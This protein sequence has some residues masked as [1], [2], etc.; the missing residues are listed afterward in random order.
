MI[1]SIEGPK[2]P[3]VGTNT[4]VVGKSGATVDEQNVTNPHHNMAVTRTWFLAFCLYF[5]PLEV[6]VI[7]GVYYMYVIKTYLDITSY[8]QAAENI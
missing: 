4:A 6:I 5:I 8:L 1:G 3:E 7:I 2:V